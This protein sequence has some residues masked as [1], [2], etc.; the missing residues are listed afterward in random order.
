MSTPRRAGTVLLIAAAL[1]AGPAAG[2]AWA[3]PNLTDGATCTQTTK[4]GSGVQTADPTGNDGS[5]DPQVLEQAQE[6]V[7]QTR[8]LLTTLISSDDP[9]AAALAEQLRGMGVTPAVASGWRQ[10]AH[11]VAD[12]LL[13]QQSPVA[14]EAA[15]VLASAGFSPTPA[16][17]RGPSAAQA[18]VERDSPSHAAVSNAS[19]PAMAATAPVSGTQAGATPMSAM[20][21]VLA[22]ATEAAAS[23]SGDGPVQVCGQ[24]PVQGARGSLE[25][26]EAS[27]SEDRGGSSNG[28]T[29]AD[30]SDD[31]AP[32]GESSSEA[33]AAGSSVGTSPSASSAS[34]EA[35]DGTASQEEGDDS[36]SGGG[37]TSDSDSAEAW[38]KDLQALTDELSAQVDD[39]DAQALAQRLRG[40]GLDESAEPSSAEPSSA[41]SAPASSTS[42]AGAASS[43]TSSAPRSLSPGRSTGPVS[44]AGAGGASGDLDFE[45]GQLA[46]ELAAAPDDPVA[47]QLSQALG[48]AG[49]AGS[50]PG[51]AAD[52][53]GGSGSSGSTGSA[54]SSSPGEGV[55]KPQND[56]SSDSGSSSRTGEGGGGGSGEAQSAAASPSS[57]STGGREAEPTS[58]ETDPESSPSADA[59]PQDSSERESDGVPP[60]TP[61]RD[62]ETAPTDQAPAATTDGAV[63]EQ[64]AECE[65]SGNWAINSGNGYSGGLQFDSS[66]WKAYGGDA[67]APSAAEASREQQI[68]VAEKLRDDRGGYGAWPACSRKLGLS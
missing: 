43:G 33:T 31:R 51:G 55:S 57:A 65:S 52:R 11:D 24:G 47:Q 7:A 30:L 17:L 29:S 48:S 61:G 59:S 8:A 1:T 45:I 53:D 38:S 4:S 3:E 35:T 37:R 36:A 44:S 18:A 25:D 21:A 49:F 34:G 39:P 40:R 62:N 56:P 26:D 67:Y 60:T 27:Q 58:S 54:T 68:A 32:V 64:L 22:G 41:D 63:W 20:S 66:T 14:Q 15:V 13:A 42:G 10:Q 16:D 12:S 6:L 46:N 50:E 5:L 28:G 2:A 23:Q 19:L 9:R